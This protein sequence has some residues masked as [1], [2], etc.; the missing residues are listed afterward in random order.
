MIVHV[1]SFV[2]LIN[3]RLWLWLKYLGRSIAFLGWLIIGGLGNSSTLLG[4]WGG[5][6]W[7]RELALI[8]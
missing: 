6:G 8:A 5:S 3:G 1:F 2:F 4:S 7:N